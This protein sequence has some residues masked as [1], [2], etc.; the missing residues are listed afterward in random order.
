M[1]QDT[2]VS[3]DQGRLAHALFP[4]EDEFVFLHLMIPVPLFG[5][6]KRRIG[7]SQTLVRWLEFLCF[8]LVLELRLTGF[9]EEKSCAAGFDMLVRIAKLSRSNCR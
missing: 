3:S 8:C 7:H 6:P 9:E 4:E 1:L 5:I 2:H